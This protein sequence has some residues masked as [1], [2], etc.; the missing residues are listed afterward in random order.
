MAKVVLY[1]TNHNVEDLYTIPSIIESN[2][3]RVLIRS[4][5]NKPENGIYIYNGAGNALT[6]AL[7]ANSASE[8]SRGS[9]THIEEGS[10]GGI[11]FVLVTPNLGAN[12]PLVVGTTDLDFNKMAFSMK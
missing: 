2:G 10:Q 6:R 5:T 7:D 11:G 9:F 4:Q 3:D 8:L 1:S 12:N